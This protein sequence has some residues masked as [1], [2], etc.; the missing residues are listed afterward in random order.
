M[1]QGKDGKSVIPGRRISEVAA[2]FVIA[3]CLILVC[4]EVMV[5]VK[6]EIAG[7][8]AKGEIPSFVMAPPGSVDQQ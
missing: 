7:R 4:A 5:N 6:R 2:A 1:D 3:V 8:S